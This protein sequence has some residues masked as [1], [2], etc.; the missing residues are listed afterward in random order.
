MDMSM[1]VLDYIQESSNAIT[2]IEG[3]YTAS[4]MLERFLFDAK[5][6]YMPIG[7]LSGGE[8][9]RLYLLK[10]DV[11]KRQDVDGRLGRQLWSIL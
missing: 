1:R 2:T 9:R 6:Q 11:Y 5:A 4:Q 3:T 7:R 8:R 10:V